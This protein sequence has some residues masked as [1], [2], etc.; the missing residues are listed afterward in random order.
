M[1]CSTVAGGAKPWK[2][3]GVGAGVGVL[4]VVGVMLARL[5]VGGAGTTVHPTATVED[6][7][8]VAII[9][10]E[11]C[12]RRIFV[13]SDR[14]AHVNTNRHNAA[15]FATLPVTVAAVGSTEALIVERVAQT[16]STMDMDPMHT[17]AIHIDWWL[18][19][20]AVT[21]VLR[22]LAM[23]LAMVSNA[24]T[25]PGLQWWWEMMEWS[26]DP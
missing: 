20:S 15:V 21:A 12:T 10:R 24:P 11:K 9:I 22:K 7:T 6:M 14:I 5:V 19:S 16:E 13:D 8:A 25:S 2:A 1:V 17:A 26:M 23:S 3:E 18:G 4:V